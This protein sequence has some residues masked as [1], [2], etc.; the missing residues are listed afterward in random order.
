M[1]HLR[2]RN[3]MAVEEE[4]DASRADCC[5]KSSGQLDRV[6]GNKV[7]FFM[8]YGKNALE[9]WLSTFLT[10]KPLNVHNNFLKGPMTSLIYWI[11]LKVKV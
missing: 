5:V 7:I 8:Y 4:E 1:V 6:A 10:P 9:Q 3:V 2:D 11:R